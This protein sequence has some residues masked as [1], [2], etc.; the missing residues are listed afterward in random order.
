MNKINQHISECIE[1]LATLTE[2]PDL[3]T[4]AMLTEAGYT[5][6]SNGS[7]WI[8]PKQAWVWYGFP[9]AWQ[10]REFEIDEVASAMLLDIMRVG[11]ANFRLEW[12]GHAW[13]VSG[14]TN[15]EFVWGENA[16]RKLAIRECARRALP[17]I[18]K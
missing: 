8:S 7:A 16:D 2:N 12:L 13:R 17:E 18:L 15:K 4:V 9:P 3:L 11:V 1:P 6:T 5:V 10:A 14:Y